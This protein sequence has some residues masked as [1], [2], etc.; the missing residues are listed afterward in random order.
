MQNAQAIVAGVVILAGGKS[1]RMGRDKATLSLPSGQRLIDYHIRQAARLNVP[2]LIANNRLALAF[3]DTLSD[4]DTAITTISDYHPS[5]LTDHEGAEGPLAGIAAALDTV[6]DGHK[7]NAPAWLMVLSCDSLITAPMLWQQLSAQVQTSIVV[8]DDINSTFDARKTPSQNSSDT[9]NNTVICLTDDTH[10]HP[11]LGFYHL[12]LASDL[13]NYLDSGERRVM[14][15]IKP[16]VQ[17]VSYPQA[18]Q[19]LTNFNTPDAFL[20]ACAVLNEVSSIATFK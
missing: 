15:F 11:L 13:K 12:S 7:D 2:I 17:T 18:W 3:D 14:A 5:T 8:P 1:S 20:R 6:A 9:V 16:K 10:L 4:I 19:P